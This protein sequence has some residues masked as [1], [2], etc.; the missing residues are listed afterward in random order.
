MGKYLFDLN[1]KVALFVACMIL[2]TLGPESVSSQA[3]D[4]SGPEW[5]KQ[6]LISSGAF[7]VPDYSFTN[8]YDGFK[9]YPNLQG[10]FFDGLSFHG[11]PTR[12]FCWYGVP[13]GMLPGEKRPAVLLVHGGG[14]TVFPEWIKKW[15]DKGYIA[16]S[17]ALE[18]QVPGVKDP[19]AP[20]PGWPTHEFS[21]PYR[22][23]FFLDVDTDTLQD[24]WFYHAV[25]DVILAN[26]LIRTFPEV[27]TSLIGVTGISWGGILV[28][29]IAGLDDRLAFSIP[30]YGCGYLQET[31]LY[32]KQLQALSPSGQSFFFVNWE[33]SNYIP[34]QSCPT[35]FV[36]G[37]NDCHFTMNSF[38]KTYHASR[39]EKYLRIEHNMLH[40][41]SPGWEPGSVYSFADYITKGSARPNQI[42]LQEFRADGKVRFNSFNDIISSKI[43]CT[44]DTGDW[45]CK[46]YEWKETA[47]GYDPVSKTIYGILLPGT[48]YYFVNSL[49]TDGNLFSSPVYK[50]S[51]RVEAAD[52]SVLSRDPAIAL[53]S[54]FFSYIP[55]I[56]PAGIP[57]YSG[58]LAFSN[59]FSPSGSTWHEQCREEDVFLSR[60]THRRGDSIHWVIRIGKGGQI[61]SFIGPYGEGIPPQ[62]R[63]WDFNT[64]RWV[65]DVWQTVNVNNT[66]NNADAFT[67]PPG[68]YLG[69]P[70][71]AGMKY[72]IHSAGTYMNDPVFLT[73]NLK[74]FYSPLM[75]SWFNKTERSFSTMHWG[76]QAH[77]PSLHKS[78]IL[79]T[80]RYRDLGSGI[81]EVTYISS[82]VGDVLVNRHNMP[83]GG[84][85]SSSLPQCWLS[86][87]DHTLERSYKT[88][89]GTDPGQLSSINESGGYFIWA[90]EG[91]DENRPAFAL[92]FGKDRHLSEFATSYNMKSTQLRWG[93]GTGDLNR[94]Y[95]VFTV[96]SSIDIR[97]GSSFFYRLYY[98]SGTMKEVHE[99]AIQLSET[100]DYGFFKMNVEEAPLTKLRTSELGNALKEDIK[101]FSVPVENMIPLYLMEDTQS[102]KQY[103]SPDLYYNVNTAPFQNPYPSGD[104]KFQTYQDREVN[105]PYDGKIKYIRLLGFGVMKEKVSANISFALIDSLILDTTKVIL[106]GNFRNKI[107][108]PLH[109]CFNC[110][111]QENEQEG[112]ILYNDFADKQYV[113]WSNPVNLTFSDRVPNPDTEGINPDPMTGKLVRGAG[114]HANLRFQLADYLELSKYS[115]FSL[116]AYFAGTEPIPPT[117]N[118][119]FI[120]RNNGSATTQYSLTQ[121]LK[122][123]KRWDEYVFDCSGAAA[124]DQYNQVWLFF[125]SPDNDGSATG[126]VVFI[127]DLKGPPLV[128][129]SDLLKF[130]TNDAGDTLTID[131][132]ASPGSLAIVNNPYFA[133]KAGKKGF[134]VP[135]KL[136]GHSSRQIYLIP[137]TKITYRDTLEL[138]FI[139]G[140]ISDSAGRV[141]LHFDGQEVKNNIPVPSYNVEFRIAEMDSPIE[142][143]RIYLNLEEKNT[144]LDGKAFFPE[145][146]PL[147]NYSYKV[148]KEGYQTVSGSFKL[149]QDTI[150]YLKISRIVKIPLHPGSKVS[151][152]PNPAS[153]SLKIISET[154]LQYAE[155][156]DLSGNIQHTVRLGSCPHSID[157][158][159]LQAGMYLLKII[160]LNSEPLIHKFIVLQ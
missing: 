143:A 128:I 67:P 56:N 80:T 53:D 69:R 33:P 127:D 106:P 125:T 54:I 113:P 26:S 133:L 100:A 61:Y 1:G 71:V 130:Y 134:E 149:E 81:L 8:E 17:I 112:M 47:A 31:P 84:V 42:S 66:L 24:Q 59:I 43:Y 32:S 132:S 37:T 52:T 63:S 109:P 38:N 65:D 96:V 22:N 82:N 14:G 12:V 34:L 88:F 156:L 13:S 116:K 18:G 122:S 95:S 104:P 9:V 110:A 36:N 75:A 98:I 86:K 40:G 151:I 103:I 83:W 121:S 48:L 123:L 58:E 155:I 41:H 129:R 87:P 92:V 146:N 45:D 137:Q 111:S 6:N 78:G 142:G 141:L 19:E 119:R 124:R 147:L 3:L 57:E 23:G 131:F 157:L 160:S 139:A 15:N 145:L 29:V 97:P 77:I 27:D 25:A 2:R 60:L 21:G 70:E 120:L 126:Q 46:N 115:T 107:W 114:A 159:N 102:G 68:T 91:S 20:L 93:D 148:D 35:L 117:W 4:A 51:V 16:L 30:V 99:T 74:P 150:I 101:L 28:N 140:T 72:F 76:Q 89:G 7:E 105:K 79:N 144:D 50:S 152:F 108:I 135:L 11:K 73:Q 10:L 94:D 44:V 5:V 153:G 136:G 64:S 85:R 138:S 90:S 118:L 49:G 39:N 62:Y 158:S 154:P 55:L